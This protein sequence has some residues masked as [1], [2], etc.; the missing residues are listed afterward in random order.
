M[1]V[2]LPVAFSVTSN[3]C[4]LELSPEIC[5]TVQIFVS[6]VKLAQPYSEAL[7]HGLTITA[8]VLD[9]ELIS[10]KAF[11]HW[12]QHWITTIRLSHAI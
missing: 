2:T 9:V 8:A 6:E 12:E 1:L 7:E 4:C 3:L 10:A 11:Q 5:L